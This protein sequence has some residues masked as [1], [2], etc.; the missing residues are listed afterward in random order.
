MQLIVKT[1]Y[2]H[3]TKVCTNLAGK[4][5]SLGRYSSLASYILTTSLNCCHEMFD[6]FK[7]TTN[8]NFLENPVSLH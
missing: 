3:F 5:R 7:V 4:R 8:V 6:V 1:I 2:H